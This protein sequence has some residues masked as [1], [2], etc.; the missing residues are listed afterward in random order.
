MADDQGR[1]KGDKVIHVLPQDW[2]FKG[3]IFVTVDPKNGVLARYECGGS[4]PRLTHRWRAR[5]SPCLFNRIVIDEFYS[6]PAECDRVGQQS[7]TPAYDYLP[8][9]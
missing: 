9:A 4:S 1:A 2:V 7:Y 5:V 8:C 3:P 6:D